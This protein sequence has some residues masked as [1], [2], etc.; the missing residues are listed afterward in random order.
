MSKIQ[1]KHIPTEFVLEAMSHLSAI[2]VIRANRD[3]FTRDTYPAKVETDLGIRPQQLA[4]IWPDVP[5]KVL[6]SKM[7]KMEQEELLFES[8]DYY[9]IWPKGLTR[10]REFRASMGLSLLMP[11]DFLNTKLYGRIEVFDNET[12]QELQGP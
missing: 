1:T 6:R 2:P 4:A 9:T 3:R 12:S 10:L 5:E 7:R 11:Q 8:F